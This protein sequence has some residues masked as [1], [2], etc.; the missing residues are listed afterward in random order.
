MKSAEV[1]VET[2]FRQNRSSFSSL[3]EAYKPRHVKPQKAKT[4]SMNFKSRSQEHIDHT[5]LYFGYVPAT[6]TPTEIDKFLLNLLIIDYAVFNHGKTGIYVHS[7][8]HG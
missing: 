6:P 8:L 7:F 3:V 5:Q 4:N 1:K 2:S